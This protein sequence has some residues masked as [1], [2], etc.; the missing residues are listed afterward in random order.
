MRPQASCQGCRDTE[1]PGK[2]PQVAAQLISAVT[3]TLGSESRFPIPT[4]T[5]VQSPGPPSVTGDWNGC[6]EA[7]WCIINAHAAA[8]VT[9]V[10]VTAC[11][12][13]LPPKWVCSPHEP[14]LGSPCHLH[15]RGGRQH[16]KDCVMGPERPIPW[17]QLCGTW[18]KPHTRDHTSPVSKF[19][20]V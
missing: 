16:G 12:Q 14:G 9:T 17:S 13:L 8:A 18:S 15:L 6:S 7:Y 19:W 3:D 5:L 11:P 20:S 1:R 4:P 10:T 2:L